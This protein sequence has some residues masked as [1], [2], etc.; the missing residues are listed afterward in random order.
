M[1]VKL[2]KD[3]TVKGSKLKSGTDIVVDKKLAIKLC[4]EEL[5][6]ADIDIP[7]DDRQKKSAKRKGK[8]KTTEEK[9]EVDIDNNL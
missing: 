1:I 6:V 5:A 7:C 4:Q 9:P 8:K 2:I 3:C